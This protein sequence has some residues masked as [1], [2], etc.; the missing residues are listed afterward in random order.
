M[1]APEFELWLDIEELPPGEYDPD[2]DHCDIIAKL[3]T[4]DLVDVTRI[5][6]LEV[7]GDVATI[8]PTGN[9]DPA[10]NGEAEVVVTLGDK[11]AR[12]KVKVS[13]VGKTFV[14]DYVHDVMPVLTKVG[15]NAGACHGSAA[16]RSRSQLDQRPTIAPSRTPGQQIE[17]QFVSW[18]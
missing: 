3:S 12:A 8:S 18:I 2:N 9:V 15:C 16:G 6:K 11:S 5:A 17:Q 4:G 7:T 1:S 13:G 10:K 14:P